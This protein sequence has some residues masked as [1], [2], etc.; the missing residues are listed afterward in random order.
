ML[1]CKT[2]SPQKAVNYFLQ[3]YYL[4]GT[5][6]WLGQGA[7]KLGLQGPVNNKEVFRNIAKGFSPDRS[8]RLSGKNISLKKRRA[9]IDCTFSAPKSVSLQALVA[10]DERLLTAHTKAVESVLALVQERY[11]HTRVRNG[12]ERNII[13][14]GNLVVAQFDHIETR[15]LDPH[16]HTHALVMN[17]TQLQNGEWYSHLN[18][19]VYTNKKF[20]GMAYQHQLAIEVQKLG[21]EV[22]W[23]AHGQFDIKGYT[24]EQLEDFSKRRQQILA[25]VG[26][27]SSWAE[28]EK[29]W[30][31]TRKRKEKIN[32]VELKTKWLEEAAALGITFVSPE[33][34]RPEQQ[35]EPVNFKSL[36]DAI[37][38]CSERTVAFRQEELEQFMLSE[39]LTRDV[40]HLEPSIKEHPELI[41]I[42]EQ[43]GV[44]FTTQAALQR[45][46]ATIS[47]M[48][49]GQGAVAAI[50]NSQTVKEDLA[51]T[52]LNEGQQ[53]AVLIAATTPDQLIAWQGVAGAGKTY[54]LKELQRIATSY[55]IKGLAPS[56]EAAKVLGSELKIEANTVAR[57][58]IYE[59]PE[60]I[61]PNQLWIV[62]EAGLLSAKDAY[63]LLQRAKLEQAKVLLVG[64]TKQLSA[65]EAGNPF[66]S[67]QQAG[68]TTAYLNES[69]RQRDAPEL[70]LA[71][72]L[73]ASGQV[74]AGFAQLEAHKCVKTVTKETKVKEIVQEYMLAEPAKRAA[75]LVLAG[76]NAERLEINLAIREA[77]KLEGSLG[78]E[79]PG[80]KLKAKDL[81][82]VEMGYTRHFAVGDVVMPLRN[83][84]RRGLVKGELYEVI[85]KST[86]HLKLK[87][88]DGTTLEVD[89][90]FKKAVY[91]RQQ[92][93]IAVGDR[94]RWT[95]NER[96]LGRRNGQEF[97]VT[98]IEGNNAQLQYLDGSDS[99]TIDLRKSQHLN[100]SLVSTIYSSQGKTAERV[101]IAAD[102]TIGKESFYVSVSRAKSELK[103]YTEDR[104]RLLE[105]ACETK[106]KETVLE[107]LRQQV[108]QQVAAESLAVN[109]ETGEHSF[110]TERPQSKR[111]SSSITPGAEVRST[112]APPLR[113]SDTVQSPT[114]NVP[115]R[116]TVTSPIKSG[117]EKRQRVVSN[118]PSPKPPVKRSTEKQA[119]MAAL[120][121]SDPAKPKRV[122][123]AEAF[124]TPGSIG[125]APFDIDPAHWKELVEGSAIHPELVQQNVQTAEGNGVYDRLLSTRLEK[126]GGSGQ[127]VTRPAAKLM[128]AYEKVAKGGWWA[129]SGIDARSLPNLKPGEQPER[130]LWGSFKADE[131]RVDAEKSQRQG[132]TEFIKYEH[133]LGEERQLFLFEVLDALAERIYN[134]HGIY[135]TDLEKQ[136]DF[137]YVVYKYNLPVTLAEGAK[138]TLSSLSQGEITIGLSGVNGGYFSRDQDKNRLEQRVLHPEL[139]VFA[140]PGRE[141]RFAFD[142]DTKLSTIF[143][144]RRELVRTGELLEQAECN[145]RVVQWEK[146][147]GLD[148]LIV[149]QGH[150]A[151]AKAQANATPLAWE[152]KRH[153]RSEYTRLS[154][155]VRK[156]QPALTGIAVDVEVYKLA[157][158]KGDIRDGARTIAQSDQSRLLQT[159]LPLKEARVAKLAYVQHVEQQLGRTVTSTAETSYQDELTEQ[160]V[161]LVEQQPTD[162][163]AEIAEEIAVALNEAAEEQ[164]VEALVAATTALVQSLA[165][166]QRSSAPLVEALAK[167]IQEQSI[168]EAADPALIAALQ[169]VSQ[170]LKILQESDNSRLLTVQ[171]S[172]Q[173][174]QFH[175][176]TDQSRRSLDHRQLPSSDVRNN[177]TSD[178][179]C[180]APRG[181]HPRPRDN[182]PRADR[183]SATTARELSEAISGAIELQEA[184]CLAGSIERF[185]RSLRQYQFSTRSAERVIGGA[186]AR[187]GEIERY[188][189]S[190]TE[191]LEQ[192]RTK[193]LLNAIAEHVELTAV[194]SAPIAQAL[195]HLIAQLNQIQSLGTD[196]AVHQIDKAI[197]AGLEQVET[198]PLS[199]AESQQSTQQ[200][201]DAISNHAESAAIETVPVIQAL[202]AFI[203]KLGQSQIDRTIRKIDHLNT[204]IDD[205]L[206]H[207]E[208]QS[209]NQ[210]IRLKTPRHILKAIADYVEETTLDSKPF[211]QALQ[212]ALSQL[213]QLQSEESTREIPRFDQAIP[214]YLPAVEQSSAIAVTDQ[215]TTQ[216]IL[217]ALVE[218]IEQ[219]AIN[220]SPVSSA[221]GE[222][223]TQLNQLQIN[224]S[225]RVVEE[226]NTAISDYRCLVKNPGEAVIDREQAVR[227]IAKAISNHIEQTAVESESVTNA[228]EQLSQNLAQ[229]QP[230]KTTKGINQ[231]NTKNPNYLQEIKGKDVSIS[232]NDQLS[233]DS[234]RT[235][236]EVENQPAQLIGGV[237][238]LAEA[239]SETEELEALELITDAV[240]MLN[241][242]LARYQPT[243]VGIEKLTT[244][245]EQI[246]KTIDI[247]TQRQQTGRLVDVITHYVEH[248]VVQ[249]EPIVQAFE[250]LS[251]NLALLQ[252]SSKVKTFEQLNTAIFNYI[253]R[254]SAPLSNPPEPGTDVVAEL[255]Q[256]VDLPTPALDLTDGREWVRIKTD[257]P[258]LKRYNNEVGVVVGRIRVARSEQVIVKIGNYTPGFEHSELEPVSSV[259][260]LEIQ[261][262]Q[263]I[264]PAHDT[265][266]LAWQAVVKQQQPQ[267]PNPVEFSPQQ[268]WQQYSQRTKSP[269]PVSKQLE[270][271]R[272]AWSEG[273][274]ETQIRQI[275]HAN[276]YLQRFGEKGVRDLVELPL[277]KV[278]REIAVLQQ[279]MPSQQ[280]RQEKSKSQGP[281]I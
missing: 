262:S 88:H 217:D 139:K 160:Q 6:R 131:P 168:L 81:T 235:A 212:L 158:L 243:N 62:D 143:N 136:S 8:Q 7:E 264:P 130:K 173:Q 222:L 198:P 220:V 75:T 255:K 53:Q 79:A 138:K 115:F 94:L 45:E 20:L 154:R 42:P 274:P 126:I 65:V 233:P 108:K 228:L 59:P 261:Q 238:E 22:E 121:K 56:A 206:Q 33:M 5:S 219:E 263:T 114:P 187:R 1:T 260:K 110:T 140:T 99:E 153:Y 161:S 278:K 250:T 192:Q 213:T 61:E 273:V 223:S 247:D 266:Q 31:A 23:H 241:C 82:S 95:K 256:C 83:Y 89:T 63:A 142:H 39:G 193:Q 176:R 86:D 197:T 257:R 211:V 174:E 172:Q 165:Q 137:W 9:A 12:D 184:Q 265:Q 87:G 150:Q 239:I 25:T 181:N 169:A 272:L 118:Q 237:R 167:A 70:K 68:M 146:D 34:P 210:E 251:K 201:L 216:D 279:Q 259:P 2:V 156:E 32:P 204:A 226:L 249:S 141:F 162:P 190:S 80:T 84:K 227:E 111:E 17:M 177:L 209:T 231:L 76:T 102:H 91:E 124:W 269:N 203:G 186:K 48:Q 64:D 199:T 236:R 24:K 205:H 248:S 107:A 41:C 258:Q 133:P 157:V 221:L 151:Y 244:A 67:L 117:D 18:E 128:K 85:G 163:L 129:K 37:A 44:R 180:Q 268:M 27:D 132:K 78:A 234:S 50:N 225:T 275:L 98:A 74:E 196:R 182:H 29:A 16:L 10:G 72:D 229:F 252:I 38:H 43:K 113:R 202:E 171:N 106:A 105:L 112:V 215:Q 93:E 185:N 218:H 101:L 271:V 73:I 30:D 183:S 47:L 109:G 178:G 253:Q 116:S 54:A 164:E 195:E 69:Q 254:S 11:S 52:T 207:A 28:R 200:L 71:V 145:V 125:A 14:T 135:P 21:Y 4:E 134:K 170:S 144:V 103:L 57:H 123:P 26:P 280:H 155:Q 276:P 191:R 66:K 267:S 230:T 49:Q 194:D 58:L 281:E 208:S 188:H 120:M 55:N 3:G 46:L 77:L 148:D 159:D 277:S 40:S 242:S 246:R 92:I 224:K 232:I 60:E 189:D 51:K 97:T 122:A 127:Y 149:N 166:H 13:K 175:E 119:E 152:A 214:K 240:T 179:A 35:P 245:I 104:N 100:Y 96:K 19:A 36:D 15:E 147:K 90:G 270:V